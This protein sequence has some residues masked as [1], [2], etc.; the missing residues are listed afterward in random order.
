[1][2]WQGDVGVDLVI[3]KRGRVIHCTV[4]QSSGHE[5][6]DDATCEIFVKRARFKPAIDADGNP[7]EEKYHASPVKWRLG[8]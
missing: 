8:S 2:G 7:I 3:S 6:L 1:M 5:V 4:Y